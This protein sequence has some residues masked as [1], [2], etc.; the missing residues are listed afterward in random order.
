VGQTSA[1]SRSHAIADH[2]LQGEQLHQSKELGLRE[3][4]APRLAHQLGDRLIQLAVRRRLCLGQRDRDPEIA[5]RWKLR[6]HLAADAPQHVRS[7]PLAQGV[8]VPRAD[9][10]AT[11]VDPH[12]VPARQPPPR[13]ERVL[14]DPFHDRRE[15]L[16]AILHRRP[17]KHQPPGGFEALDHARRLGLPVLDPLSL[18][19][20]HQIGVVAANQREVAQSAAAASARESWPA[21]ADADELRA[22]LE[23]VRNVATESW[24]KLATVRDRATRFRDEHHHLHVAGGRIVRMAPVEDDS[25]RED[26]ADD[27]PF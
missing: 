1:K 19:E 2:A 10:F 23:A 15:L 21:G 11:A 14:V 4:P 27:L 20:D 13:L 3:R 22:V 12:R 25:T 26:A 7:Q 9:H 8:E 6:Q 16:D 5:P 18:I 24:T 17:G